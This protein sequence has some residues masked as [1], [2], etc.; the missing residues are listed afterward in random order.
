MKYVLVC[1]FLFLLSSGMLCTGGRKKPEE[2]HYALALQELLRDHLQLFESVA[3]NELE[4]ESMGWMHNAGELYG[5]YKGVTLM[6][7][8]TCQQ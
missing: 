8:L 6:G 1:A 2:P 4:Y 5:L 7:S 3:S